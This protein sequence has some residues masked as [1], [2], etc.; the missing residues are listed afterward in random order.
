MNWDY[1]ELIP[2]FKCRELVFNR[3]LFDRGLSESGA[4]NIWV[5]CCAS[6]LP[7]KR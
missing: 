5:C 6:M 3:R 4:D 7:S 1:A 2:I